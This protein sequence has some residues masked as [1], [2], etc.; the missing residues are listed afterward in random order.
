[1]MLLEVRPSNPRAIRLYERFGFEVVGRR[2]N[3]Y[4]A[5]HR[6]REDAIVMRL[7]LDIQGGTHELA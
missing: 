2:K 5:K 7:P 1:G 4:P 6:T 3:Y